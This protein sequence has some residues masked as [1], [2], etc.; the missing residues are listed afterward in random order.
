YI[1]ANLAVGSGPASHPVNVVYTPLCGTGNGSVGDVLRAAGYPIH[2]YE[3]HNTFDGTFASVPFRMPNPEV[4]E[5]ASPALALA[6]ELGS[7]MVL[8]SDPDA[9]RL[10][11]FAKDASGRWHYFNGNQ[12]A[13]VLAYYLCLDREI[14]PQR[15]GVLIK[16]LVTTRMIQ[17]I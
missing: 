8:S 15:S 1:S 14:G 5:A 11:V 17:R 4:P 10:G 2:V 6:R 3:P 16:T 12:I 9:D 13:A 7:D